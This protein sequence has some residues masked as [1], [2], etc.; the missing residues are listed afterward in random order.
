M[1]TSLPLS[2]FLSKCVVLVAHRLCKISTLQTSYLHIYSIFCYFTS[3]CVHN[4]KN[5]IKSTLIFSRFSRHISKNCISVSFQQ[6]IDVKWR[7]IIT[8]GLL[9]PESPAS[10]RAYFG[11]H[12][13]LCIFLKRRGSNTSNFAMLWA[14]QRSAFQKEWIVV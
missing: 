9:F 5:S 13:S 14:F 6:F 3:L 11:C 1:V 7:W 12:N 10:F 2:K 8:W 4:V